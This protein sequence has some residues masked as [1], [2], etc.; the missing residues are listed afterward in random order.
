MFFLSNR[1]VRD[2]WQDSTSKKSGWEITWS[3]KNYCFQVRYFKKP[4]LETKVFLEKYQNGLAQIPKMIE[5]RKGEKQW[6]PE[7][8]FD[9]IRLSLTRQIHEHQ[10]MLPIIAYMIHICFLKWRMVHL[11]LD[12]VCGSLQSLLVAFIGFVMSM[13]FFSISMIMH[14]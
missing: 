6:D 3:G 12:D 14:T 10:G 4:H 2:F 8:K 7:D 5:K 9:T 13:H 1:G 11:H